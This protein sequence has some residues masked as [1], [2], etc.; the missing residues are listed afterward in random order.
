[1][2]A[3]GHKFHLQ[4]WR[5]GGQLL[6]DGKRHM[7]DCPMCKQ[8]GKVKDSAEADLLAAGEP[9]FSPPCQ[10]GTMELMQDMRDC[11]VRFVH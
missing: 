1:M 4:C 9:G 7:L 10:L 11:I 3:R 8:H 5:D 2:D 6:I